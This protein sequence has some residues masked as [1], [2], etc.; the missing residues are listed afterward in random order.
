MH[1]TGAASGWRYAVDR[2]RVRCGEKHTHRIP[3]HSRIDCTRGTPRQ[4]LGACRQPQRMCP[5]ALD[6]A[7]AVS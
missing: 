1:A 3:D 7:K 5:A 4:A 6:S 2:F